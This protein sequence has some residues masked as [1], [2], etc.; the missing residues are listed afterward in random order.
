M[1]QIYPSR[2]CAAHKRLVLSS[3][4]CSYTKTLM[5]LFEQ[6]VLGGK[7]NKLL[8]NLTAEAHLKLGC[9]QSLYHN[10]SRS[11]SSQVPQLT[12]GMSIQL[13]TPTRATVCFMLQTLKKDFYY[14]MLIKLFAWI[15]SQLLSPNKL[16]Q[17]FAP[18]AFNCAL[19]RK[20]GSNF[21]RQLR[22]HQQRALL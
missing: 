10:K 7:G 14:T 1:S 22:K 21:L 17:I 11:K 8:N 20:A 2:P 4:A 9:W 12:L 18:N 16:T 13:G 5:L 6:I 19:V 15:L 3:Y